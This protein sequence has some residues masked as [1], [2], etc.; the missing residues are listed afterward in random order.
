MDGKGRSKEAK[1]KKEEGPQFFVDLLRLSS[2]P[3][4]QKE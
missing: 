3:L 4:W 2:L 1:E